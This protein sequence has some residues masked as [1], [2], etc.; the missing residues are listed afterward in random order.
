[1][2]LL[3]DV[4]WLGIA[5]K[6]SLLS[7]YATLRPSP[8]RFGYPL[9]PPWERSYLVVKS[10]GTTKAWRR[11]G[12]ST[13]DIMIPKNPK[14]RVPLLRKKSGNKWHPMTITITIDMRPL[15]T[16]SS[17]IARQTQWLSVIYFSEWSISEYSLQR[18]Y[19]LH[20]TC[21]VF[22]LLNLK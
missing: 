10:E 1:M 7:P 13:F 4:V 21:N 8:S 19:I 18:F 2:M 9:P 6:L 14:I 15:F 5:S 22:W 17:Q 12:V 20:F 11:Q 16:L 3:R